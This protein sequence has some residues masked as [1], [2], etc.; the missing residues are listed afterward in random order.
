MVTIQNDGTKLQAALLRQQGFERLRLVVLDGDGVLRDSSALVYTALSKA[1]ES[2]GLSLPFDMDDLRRIRTVQKYCDGPGAKVLLAVQREGAS[3][4]EVLARPNLGAELDAIVARHITPADDRILDEI[5]RKHDQ[6]I[7]EGFT[8]VGNG[9]VHMVPGAAEAIA[10]LKISGY[11]V[12]VFSNAPSITNQQSGFPGI[13]ISQFYARLVKGDVIDGRPVEGKPSGDG[14]TRIMRMFGASPEEV[15]YVGDSP[16][17]IKVA[18]NA[19]V[20]IV[21][22]M[23]GDGSLDQFRAGGS[24][25]VFRNLLEFSKYVEVPRAEGVTPLLRKG[26]AARTGEVVAEGN[27]EGSGRLLRGG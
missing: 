17:D 5:S 15:V 22:V 27:S 3:L 8:N 18:R 7:S 21:S 12:A 20:T 24:D 14:V 13:D 9:L 26:S 16:S 10:R 11:T 6:I 25:W 19:G 23:S 4:K 2:Q 1:V